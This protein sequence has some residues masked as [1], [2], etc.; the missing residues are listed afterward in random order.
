LQLR[1]DSQRQAAEAELRNIQ[2]A[3]VELEDKLAKLE[4]KASQLTQSLKLDG[5]THRQ[6]ETEALRSLEEALSRPTLAK[7]LPAIALDQAWQWI[8]NSVSMVIDWKYARRNL[9]ERD[10]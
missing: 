3:K 6:I 10:F 7:S 2:N 9:P 8:G 4:S 1:T 5:R